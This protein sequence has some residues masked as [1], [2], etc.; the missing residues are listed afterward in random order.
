MLIDISSAWKGI[1]HKVWAGRVVWA[2][3]KSEGGLIVFRRKMQI[4]T[5][6]HMKKVDGFRGK[7]IDCWNQGPELMR[8]HPS[9]VT[10]RGMS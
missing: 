7:K 9:F 10:I 6:P 2:D 8:I 3:S 5:A 4:R 1:G